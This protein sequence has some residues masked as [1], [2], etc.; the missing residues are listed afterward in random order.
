[1]ATVLCSLIGAA[2]EKQ[3]SKLQLNNSNN[4]RNFMI[5]VRKGTHHSLQQSDIRGAWLTGVTAGMICRVD[6]TGTI[7]LGGDGTT[8]IRGFAINNSTDGDAIE[9]QKIALYTLDGNSQIETDQTENAVNATNY[10][11]GTALYSKGATGLV[12]VTST[13]NGSIIGW[14]QGIRSLQAS[15]GQT[16][17]GQTY[18]SIDSSGNTSSKTFAFKAQV[19]VPVLG[20][21]LAATA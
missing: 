18:T 13:A 16:Q 20:I 6:S 4:Q 10:P 19:N 21:K 3:R 8:G 15:P 14:V 2:F 17:S 12:T 11:V 7:A 5:N 1:M 9:S